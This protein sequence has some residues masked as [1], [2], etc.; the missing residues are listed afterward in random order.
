MALDF[1]PF[2]DCVEA[3]LMGEVAGQAAY[4]T[5]GYLKVGGFDT[6]DMDTLADLLALWLS[7]TLVTN[8]QAGITWTSVK[9]TD[10]TSQFAPVV[11]STNTLPASGAVGGAALTN[12]ACFVMS[13]KTAKR[14]RSFRGRNYIPSIPPAGLA[15]PTSWSGS[16]VTAQE[17]AYNDLALAAATAG[18]TPV[19]L[20]RQENGVRRTTGVA[21]PI[22]EYIGRTAVGTQRRRIIGHGI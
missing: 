12:Q 14:G 18:W 3:V 2:A 5:Q 7:D 11:F 21:E 13:M 4:L 1:I 19:I 20:S 10:L 17:S 16:E 8:Q 6:T 15:T 9:V 22:T